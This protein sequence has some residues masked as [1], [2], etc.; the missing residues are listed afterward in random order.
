MSEQVHHNQADKPAAVPATGTL[1]RWASSLNRRSPSIRIGAV[2]ALALVGGFVAWLVLRGGGGSSTKAAATRATAVSVSQ[3]NDLARSL[4]HPLFWLGPKGGYTYELTQTGSGKVYVRYLPPGVQVGSDQPYLTV[5]TY[6]FTGAFSAL[7]KQ[8]QE[9]GAVATRIPQGGLAVLDNGYP[10]STHVAY[11][12]VDYQVEVF[13]PRPAAAMQTV[14]AGHLAALGGLHSDQ[15]AA[16]ARP[17]AVSAAVLRSAGRLA[18]P[19]DLLGRSEDGHTYEL[20]RTSNG[21]VYIRYL[22]AGVKAGSKTAYLTVATYPFPAALAAIKR[23]AKGD[24]TD[25]IELAGGGLA[26]VDHT[27]PKSIHL[28]YPKSDYQVEVFD[29]S[30][31]RARQIVSAGRIAAVP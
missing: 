20:T 21:N 22:P 13:D 2:V 23:Q 8:S 11:P 27:Y 9:K 18:R 6:P 12:G 24:R 31:A 10:Q 3:L 30:P 16:G 29:P 14:A 5:G 7:Q 25:T 19:P 4:D 15:S 1:S 17:V 28:A 26:L